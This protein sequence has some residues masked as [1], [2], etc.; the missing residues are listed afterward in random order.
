MSRIAL[1]RVVFE[2]NIDKPLNEQGASPGLDKVF[3]LSPKMGRYPTE[4]FL[5]GNLII[6]RDPKSGREEL[7]PLSFVRQMRVCKKST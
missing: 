5:D 6:V 3:E 7:V 2:E 1:E 4:L